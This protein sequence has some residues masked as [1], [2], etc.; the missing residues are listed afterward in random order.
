VQ[1]ASEINVTSLPA[2]GIA[3]KCD[4]LWARKKTAAIVEND[5]G[6]R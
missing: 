1:K 2:N 6:R 3:Q 5:E 4:I